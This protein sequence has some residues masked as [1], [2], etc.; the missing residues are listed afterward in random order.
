[1]D[2]R[3]QMA[4]YGSAL[5]SLP[6]VKIDVENMTATFYADAD[7]GVVPGRVKS[8]LELQG[9]EIDEKLG[10]LIDMII[11]KM[12]EKDL[13]KTSYTGSGRG[14]FRHLPKGVAESWNRK[15]GNGWTFIEMVKDSIEKRTIDHFFHVYVTIDL[16]SKKWADPEGTHWPHKVLVKVDIGPRH[17]ISTGPGPRDRVLPSI[18]FFFKKGYEKVNSETDLNDS[19]F[20]RS[21]KEVTPFQVGIGQSEYGVHVDYEEREMSFVER[22]KSRAKKGWDLF[23]T[24]GVNAARIGRRLNR[25]INGEPTKQEREIQLREWLLKNSYDMTAWPEAEASLIEKAKQDLGDWVLYFLDALP[26]EHV[27]HLKWEVCGTCNGK[28]THVNPSID[29][30]GLTRE[31]FDQDPDFEEEYFSG[32]YDVQCYECHG[33]TT[34]LT[35]NRERTS[36]GAIKMADDH[37]K[38]EASYRRECEAERR[39][40][41]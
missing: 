16:G 41:A 22:I 17:W 15:T 5:S 11:D 23:S 6:D 19:W 7:V 27:L 31:D 36:P 3:D 26:V 35:I 38:D 13:L 37:F 8:K 40:G 9:E 33:R 30:H 20:Y 18:S 14:W 2:R 28:G 29:A 1:M 39:M 21:D 4:M 25:M 10:K 12:I 32:T 24:G 34:S